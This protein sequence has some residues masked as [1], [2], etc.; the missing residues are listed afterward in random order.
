MV[1]AYVWLKEIR[2]KKLRRTVI[3]IKLCGKFL[4]K[5]LFNYGKFV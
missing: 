2:I 5:L 3:I 1:C 4:E